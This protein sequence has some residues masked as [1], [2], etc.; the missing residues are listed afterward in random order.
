M[1]SAFVDH[2]A[3]EEIA[4]QSLKA[5][6][7]TPELGRCI[8]EVLGSLSGLVTSQGRLS[9]PALDH[10]R[11]KDVALAI[12]S[13]WLSFRRD[14]E[15]I[16][17]ILSMSC[18]CSKPSSAQRLH[19]IGAMLAEGV[20]APAQPMILLCTVRICELD[21]QVKDVAKMKLHELRS[22]DAW[23]F[24]SADLLPH[25]PEETIRGYLDWLVVNDVVSI[26]RLTQAFTAV[27]E[28]TW[29]ITTPV[30]YKKRIFPQHF[31]NLTSRW[32][33]IWIKSTE[34]ETQ[35]LK[36]PDPIRLA[37]M[38][39]QLLFTMKMLSAEF[40]EPAAVSH[41][42]R[43]HH[44]DVL[45]S[46]NRVVSTTSE[47]LAQVRTPQAKSIYDDATAMVRDIAGMIQYHYS[48]SLT[49]SPRHHLHGAMIQLSNNPNARF[50]QWTTLIDGMRYQYVRQTC[51]APDCTRTTEQHG[52]AFRYCTGCLWISYCSSTCQ[53]KAWRRPDNLQHR[54]ICG[55][56]RVLRSRFSFPHRSDLRMTRRNPPSFSDEDGQLI[57]AI[58]AHFTALCL[59]DLA[60]VR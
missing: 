38:L 2:N 46:C 30:I 24:S 5:S 52:H 18:E 59:H 11:K 27:V 19:A 60:N 49:F 23:P 13:R 56:I 43:I 34:V 28:Y 39:R 55:R 37:D 58:N 44:E 6:M 32:A 12:T 14:P 50:V 9:Q 8:M 25:G 10:S 20:A 29:P 54:A 57:D 41:Y 51:G 47:V 21:K 45:I 17:G 26:S 35:A 7:G 36:S 15:Q 16:N 53:K 31:M 1:N 33:D 3:L 48:D 22:R 42:L 4:L 40:A